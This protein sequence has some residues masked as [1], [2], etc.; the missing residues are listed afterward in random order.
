MHSSLAVHFS[1]AINQPNRPTN[2]SPGGYASSSWI[3][4]ASTME[5]GCSACDVGES[6][7][8]EVGATACSPCTNGTYA[9]EAGT[10]ECTACDCKWAG[11]K[12]CEVNTGVCVCS[13]LYSGSHCETEQSLIVR[14][15]L[16]T[17][18]KSN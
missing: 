18:V 11:T 14:C 2:P 12:Y 7:N 5:E 13:G 16:G 10:S 15:A 3:S 8:G 6:T 4:T 9:E 1:A 17:T